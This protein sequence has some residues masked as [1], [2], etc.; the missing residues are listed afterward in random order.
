MTIS[1]N[2]IVFSFKYWIYIFYAK[3]DGTEKSSV[4]YFVTVQHPLCILSSWDVLILIDACSGQGNQMASICWKVCF[5]KIQTAIGDSVAALVISRKVG[6][7]RF[8]PCP[9]RLYCVVGIGFRFCK[10]HGYLVNKVDRDCCHILDVIPVWYVFPF[11][12]WVDSQINIRS[13]F[14]S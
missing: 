4:F 10:C 8:M 5:H 6:Q 14:L 3:R 12:G 1:K 13:R 9:C 11:I 7:D 2:I